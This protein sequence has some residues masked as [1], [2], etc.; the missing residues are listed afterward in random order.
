ML[1]SAV[2]VEFMQA[3]TGRQFEVVESIG[4]VDHIELRQ[5]ARL[6]VGR[7]LAT[8]LAVPEAFRFSTGEGVDHRERSLAAA[9]AEGCSR[10]SLSSS[11]SSQCHSK[12]E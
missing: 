10:Q 9:K 4:S 11:N 1:T 7:Q 5:C 3:V 12:S 6:D 8:A 2:A